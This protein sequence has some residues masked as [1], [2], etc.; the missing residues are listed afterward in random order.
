MSVCPT[1]EQVFLTVD[2]TPETTPC[3]LDLLK[4]KNKDLKSKNED[5][6][7][8]RIQI[9]KLENDVLG[10]GLG[11]FDLFLAVIAGFLLFVFMFKN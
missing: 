11:L 5:I 9:C 7:N 1:E 6:D 3:V 4:R 2:F 10:V 8:K